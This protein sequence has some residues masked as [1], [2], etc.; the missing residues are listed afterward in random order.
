MKKTMGRQAV[1]IALVA[2]IMAVSMP[3][4]AAEATLGEDDFVT[5]AVS[6]VF[7]KV[8]QYTSGEK[9]IITEDAKG[10][11]DMMGYKVDPNEGK[12]PKPPKKTGLDAALNEPL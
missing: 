8:G 7:Q 12:L 6:D 4:F 3:I 10:V 9:R 5:S 11:D 2:M 1:S